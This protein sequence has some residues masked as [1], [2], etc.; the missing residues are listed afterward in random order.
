MPGKTQ[1]F[2]PQSLTRRKR[3]TRHPA[4]RA[5]R[6]DLSIGT[7]QRVIR[8]HPV[9]R[10][11]ARKKGLLF[12]IVRE[13]TEFTG[14]QILFPRQ[15]RQGDAPWDP[16]ETAHLRRIGVDGNKG[17]FRIFSMEDIPVPESR[18]RIAFIGDNCFQINMIFS[19]G[20]DPFPADPARKK[21]FTVTD[22]LCLIIGNGVHFII[23]PDRSGKTVQRK[24]SAFTVS[25]EKSAVLYVPI[26]THVLFSCIVFVSC[27]KYDPVKRYSH[28]DRL[29]E[30]KYFFCFFLAVDRG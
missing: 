22:H 12:Q 1:R 29:Q 11:E 9:N 28:Y 10:D 24:T 3:V 25:E 16:L 14:K 7:M 23:D 13:V 17:V 15:I 8:C 21:K 19:F 27:T 5:V 4:E 18:T 30:K 20:N 26:Q 2:R 6:C